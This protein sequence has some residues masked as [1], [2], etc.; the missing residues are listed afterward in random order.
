MTESGSEI[1]TEIGTEDRGTY[2]ELD[3]RPAVRFVR[4]YRHPIEKVWTAVSEPAGMAAWFPSK[5]EIEPRKGGT[6][7]FSDDPNIPGA[8]TGTVLRYEPPRALAFTWEGDELHLTLDPREDGGC[9]LTL[10][11]VLA[12]RDTAALV[13]AGWTVCLAELTRDLS[14]APAAEDE[15]AEAWRPLYEEYV[16]SGMPSGAPIPGEGEED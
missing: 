3:G 13:S 15:D 1:G 5:V 9:T 7:T 2:V 10:V 16:A 4:T 8:S 14:G 6:I 12:A 11:N